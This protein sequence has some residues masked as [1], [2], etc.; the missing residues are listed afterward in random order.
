MSGATVAR[1]AMLI[2]IDGWGL[3][4][5]THGNAILNAQTPCMDR[6]AAEYPY[7]RLDASGHSVGLPAGVMG[8]SEVGHLTI[9][10]GRAEYQDLVLIDL[11]IE[12]G[13]LASKPAFAEALVRAKSGN[14]RLHF[15]GLVSDGGVH[16][17]IRHLLAM[18][19]EAQ[20]AAV[21]ECFIQ[22]FTDGRDTPPNSCP[23]YIAELQ[24]HLD[25]NAYG[26]IATVVGRYY[27]MDRDKRWE[28]VHIA[29]NAMITGEG[30]TTDK[31]KLLEVIAARH[32]ANEMDEFLK[33]IIV[34][35]DKGRIKA[36]D[37][38]IFIDFRSDR[39][40]EIVEVLGVKPPYDTQ[41]L[42]I[43]ADI[44]VVCMTQYKK[45]FPLPIIFPKPTM[46]NVLAE[47]LSKQNVRQFHTAET[48]KYAH[49]TFFFNGG[50]EAAFEGEDRFLVPSP[51]VATYDLM[52][53]MS[54]IQ[55]G[56]VVAETLAKQEYPFVVCNF[57][58]P[59]MVGHTG[60]YEAAV[61]GVETTDKAIAIIY[62][63]CMEHDYVLFV[64]ADHG[65]AEV[66]IA[67]DGG[68]HTAHTTNLVPFVMASKD[69][70]FTFARDLGTLQDVAPT[71]LQVMGLPVPAEM[72]GK[73]FLA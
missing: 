54:A 73:S 37:T 20:K 50:R 49:V 56:Q 3:S 11:C 55:V 53:E 2:C 40:R 67:P 34:N 12:R 38:L 28:R 31:S 5:D 44:Q 17:H 25:A 15:L 24:N 57:A 7:A 6:L 60:K 36:G 10:S 43:P 23:K 19:S 26:E 51:K 29:V 63:A 64:T 9:G 70:A 30:E 27:A 1:K 39:M 4:D 52:P 13:Q 62:E 14:G 72:D 66:M 35:G 61:R 47:W 18:I 16:S 71:V 69:K 42:E 32:A 59:D 22:V 65:N 45:D 21:P 41:G 58:P 68:N 46:D 8:N 33:P 48:E